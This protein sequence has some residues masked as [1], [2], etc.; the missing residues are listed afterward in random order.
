MERMRSVRHSTQRAGRG[1]SALASGDQ[2]M[3]RNHP[4]PLCDSARNHHALCDARALRV[5]Y[6]AATRMSGGA[7][8]S[9]APPG[10]LI[11]RLAAT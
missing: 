5:A 4:D 8:P 6:A 7:N 10:G 11:H 9:A 2:A 3:A 1:H